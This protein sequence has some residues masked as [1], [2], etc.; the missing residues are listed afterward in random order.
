MAS[1]YI[2]TLSNPFIPE[3]AGKREKRRN[4]RTYVRPFFF[5]WDIHVVFSATKKMYIILQ[6]NITFIMQLQLKD[7]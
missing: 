7:N 2:E 4:H 3:N 6:S 1:F 5:R